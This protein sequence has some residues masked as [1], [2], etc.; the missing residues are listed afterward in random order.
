MIDIINTAA[1]KDYIHQAV[2]EV[3]NIRTRELRLEM[4]QIKREKTT[5]DL[6][7][8]DEAAEYLNRSTRYLRDR[9]REGILPGYRDGK[10][11][12]FRT[13]D[14]NELITGTNHKQRAR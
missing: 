8:L 4:E 9:L 7:T 3:V 14:L 12:Y 5:K 6:L 2:N 13:M 11:I 10:K 1:L